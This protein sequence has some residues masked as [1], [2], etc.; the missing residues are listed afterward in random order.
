M[1]ISQL[2]SNYLYSQL[3]NGA[4][5]FWWGSL[6]RLTEGRFIEYFPCEFLADGG[7][8][9]DLAPLTWDG[10]KSASFLRRL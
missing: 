3:A 9:Q 7:I 4:W 5:S 8:G 2:E 1:E 10:K 6:T